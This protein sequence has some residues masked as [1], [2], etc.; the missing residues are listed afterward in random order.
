MENLSFGQFADDY[1]GARPGYPK[2]AIDLV[3]AKAKLGPESAVLEIGVGTGIATQEIAKTGTS[4]VGIEPS[5]NL[6][7][8]ARSVLANN[9]R[10]ELLAQSFE[11]FKTDRVFDAVL[12]AT[13]WHWLKQDDKYQRV[14]KMLKPGG[15][16]A[17]FWNSFCRHGDQVDLEVDRAYQR[18]LPGV[19]QNVLAKITD[20]VREI[21]SNDWFYI[22]H[23]QQFLVSYTY[24]ADRFVALLKTYPKVIEAPAA[25]RDQFLEAV[26]Q[27]VKTHGAVTVPVLT[28]VCIC[29]RIED[30]D[31][32]P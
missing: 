21:A 13:A 29:R 1:A 17:I 32:K 5:E 7:R 24:D 12:S 26:R 30:F 10:V 25:D 31:F 19:N 28:T 9:D 8:I 14:A 20:K 22:S 4:L 6:L 23:L 15:V 27:I 16:L 18:Y 11:D 3:I 2:E